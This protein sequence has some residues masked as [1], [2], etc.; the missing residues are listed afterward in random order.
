MVA[1]VVWRVLVGLIGA[2]LV[3]SA[4]GSAVR[5]VVLP[6]GTPDP[7]TRL[8]FGQMLRVLN[9]G[10]WVRRAN[11][12]E[13]RDRVMA[14]YAPVSL[15]VLVA[16]WLVCVLLGY[17]VMFWAVDPRPL[18]EAF[19]VSGSSVFTL[20]FAPLKT[21]VE[22]ALAFTEAGI[23]LLLVALLISYLPTMYATFAR[24][25]AAVTLLEVRAG[26]PPSAVE[27]IAR[28]NRLDRLGA[29][30]DLWEAWEGWFAD[31]EES[32]TSLAALAFFRSPQPDRSWVT[33]AGAILDTASLMA[34]AVDVPRNPQAELCIRAGYVALGR[35]AGYFRIDYD[36]QPKAGD[37]ISVTRGEF[38]AA[39]ADLR[40]RGVP[41]KADVEQAWRDFAGWR[42]N[43]DSALLGLAG[44]TMAPYAPWS[45]DRGAVYRRPPIFQK[46]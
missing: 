38:D 26:S 30:D 34:A 23:G 1:V 41:M 39:C 37:P 42:V 25:E 22:V 45:S 4:L 17:M 18:D 36:P 15:L 28:F 21:S 16:T 6:R 33:A 5:T 8:V 31:V 10:L 29:M 11:T 27:M 24:R 32:H 7:I 3:M 19:A 35:I 12:Y 2:G 9:V 40:W 14:Y 43:Y 13:A 46:R 44:L 20:G